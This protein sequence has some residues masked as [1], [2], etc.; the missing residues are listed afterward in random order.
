MLAYFKYVF[1]RQIN[2]INKKNILSICLLIKLTKYV[3]LFTT[4]N[5]LFD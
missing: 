5:S 1:T 2:F 3:N 4:Q